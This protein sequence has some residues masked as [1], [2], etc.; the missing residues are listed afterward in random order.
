MHEVIAEDSRYANAQLGGA[1][2]YATLSNGHSVRG[3]LWRCGMPDAPRLLLLPGFTEFCEKYA[4][5]MA[6]AVSLG[7]DCLAIDWPGQGRSGHLGRKA[8]A[9]HCDNFDNHIHA[10]EAL[11]NEAGWQEAPMH[12]LAHS[13]GGHLALRAAH[14][15]GPRIVSLALSAP[16][17]LPTPKP[18]RG[19]LWLARML[20]LCGLSRSHVPFTSV[21]ELETATS[22]VPSN[23]LTTD[24]AGFAWQTHWFKTQPDLRRYGATVG[25]VYA[26][27]HSALKTVLRPSYLAAIT[28]PAVL[29][30][31]EDEQVVDKEA[32]ATAAK[33]LPQGVCVPIAKARHELLNETP[34][35]DAQM[36]TEL[37]SFWRAQGLSLTA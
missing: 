28:A 25:W 3:H 27:Y 22:F 32:I 19:V 36:W 6:R 10:L 16:M 1:D 9:V 21:P 31:P 23:Q 7:F 24:P 35:I 20:K 14:Y 8:V 29:F 30:Q 34:Q 18:V 2:I 13:M 15:F 17:I 26:A 11:I 12:L 37:T 33:H 5:V 4:H